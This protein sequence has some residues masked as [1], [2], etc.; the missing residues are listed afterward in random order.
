M[1]ECAIKFARRAQRVARGKE[2]GT[3]AREGETLKSVG[4]H[5]TDTDRSMLRSLPKLDKRRRCT[6]KSESKK[7]TQSDNKNVARG[8]NEVAVEAASV[9][10]EEATSH[11]AETQDLLLGD[12]AHHIVDLRLGVKSTPT[13]HVAVADTGLMVETDHP[14]DPLLARYLDHHLDD[15]VTEALLGHLHPHVLDHHLAGSEMLLARRRDQSL[16]VNHAHNL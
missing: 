1:F 10:D 14:P 6:S 15:D 7:S 9:A 5:T 3:F 8:L 2:A 13:S 12:E 4:R 11:G 16:P